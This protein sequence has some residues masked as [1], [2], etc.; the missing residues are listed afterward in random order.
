MAHENDIQH[1]KMSGL[2]IFLANNAS[3]ITENT[4]PSP[5]SS[6]TQDYESTSCIK[7]YKNPFMCKVCQIDCN[8]DTALSAH[9]V[10]K[11]HKKKLRQLGLQPSDHPQGLERNLKVSKFLYLSQKIQKEF[12]EPV[13]GLQY[14]EEFLTETDRD[15]NE[16]RYTCNLCSVTGEIE[17]FW[18]HIIGSRHRSKYMEMVLKLKVNKDEVLDMAYEVEKREGKNINLIKRT[19]C[20]E[21]YPMPMSQRW[22]KE[23]K[24]PLLAFT[25][26]DSP[27]QNLLEAIV[28]SRQIFT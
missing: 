11:N 6:Q 13:L 25:D 4:T 17:P 18:S 10:G 21:K 26:P 12:Y 19:V 24:K 1:R 15:Q 5:S 16:P 9:L 2:G 20:D 27:V 8:S 28:R 23:E 7:D 22:K 3:T 14:V